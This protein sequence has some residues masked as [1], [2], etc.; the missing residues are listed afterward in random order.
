MFLLISLSV[1][2]AACSGDDKASDEKDVSKP[3]NSP[4][5]EQEESDNSLED[6]KDTGKGNIDSKDKSNA[7]P[8]EENLL[9]EDLVFE[10]ENGDVVMT[11]NHAEFTKEFTAT[12]GEDSISESLDTNILFHL[13]GT[14]SNDT[15][16]SFNYGHQMSQIKFKVLYDDKHEF[17]ALA[18]TESLDGSKFEG[19]SIQPLQEQ[20]IHIYAAVPLP[21]AERDKSLVLI[22]SDNDGDHEI[23]LR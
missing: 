8:L 18:A 9:T 22:I 15:V 21:V 11:I 19:A 2:L 12:T 20:I 7:T 5:V 1:I 23:D 17:Q 6:N 14:I 3:E 4:N 10:Y 13:Q 16:D